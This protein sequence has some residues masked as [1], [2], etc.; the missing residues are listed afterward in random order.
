MRGRHDVA[1]PVSEMIPAS[2]DEPATT[3]AYSDD[4]ALGLIHPRKLFG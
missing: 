4:R 1:L 3:L 2:H